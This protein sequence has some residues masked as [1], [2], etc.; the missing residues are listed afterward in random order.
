MQK[1]LLHVGCGGDVRP[2]WATD[3]Q[4]T[5]LDI[6]ESQSPDIVASMT[7][8]GDIGTYDAVYC[9]HALEH[10]FPHEVVTALSE[11]RR[12]LNPEGLAMVMVPDLED[13]KATEDVILDAPCGPI[14]GLDMIYGKRDVLAE[15]PYMAHKTGFVQDTLANAYAAA[16]F[17]K[18]ETLRLGDYNLMGIGVK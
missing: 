15:K 8:M 18:I 14:T 10:L 5:R 6:D 12:V 9:S 13:V 2:F 11:F 17:R 1:T 16:G 3:Y 7:D 4:E